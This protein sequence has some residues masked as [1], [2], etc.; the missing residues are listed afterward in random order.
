MVA[1]PFP[2]PA[3]VMESLKKRIMPYEF[4]PPP[5]FNSSLEKDPAFISALLNWHAEISKGVVALQ[6]ILDDFEP[7]DR[8]YAACGRETPDYRK[9]KINDSFRYVSIMLKRSIERGWPLINWIR[10]TWPHDP[11]IRDH[12][13]EKEPEPTPH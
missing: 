8:N 13:A 6:E 3:D 2:V 5:T 7:A 12:L 4:P 10:A 11:V 9:D 1:L